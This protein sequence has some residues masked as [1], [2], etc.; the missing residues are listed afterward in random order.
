MQTLTPHLLGIVLL[1]AG[2]LKAMPDA[3]SQ[4]VYS[5]L[6][7]RWLAAGEVALEI[8]LGLWLIF[9]LCAKQARWSAIAIFLVLSATAA[10]K[11]F[12][13]Q[14]SCN[15]FGRFIEVSPWIMF[16][17][18]LG[19]VA[20]LWFWRPEGIDKQGEPIPRATG[21]V[22]F[23]LA[24]LVLALAGL[25]ALRMAYRLPSSELIVKGPS[26]VEIQHADRSQPVEVNFVLHNRTLHDI[27]IR[28]IHTGCPRV[29]AEI[30]SKTIGGGQ[31]ASLA[32]RIHG[33]QEIDTSFLHR[34][35]VD[36]DVGYIILWVAGTLPASQTI[37]YRPHEL[38]LVKDDENGEWRERTVTI[39]IPKSFAEP[40]GD[41]SI[42]LTNCRDSKISLTRDG[43][44]TDHVEY[45]LHFL[46]SP[47]LASDWDGGAIELRMER[48]NLNIPVVIRNSPAKAG[49]P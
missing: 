49:R 1:A 14:E 7:Y 12:L 30:P 27:S 34:I 29:T 4:E 40:L 17:F 37:F 33:F 9:G 43:Q 11:G 41:T 38:F 21:F 20:G 2:T 15:C 8:T 45:T 6:G 42:T 3:Y 10:S 18:D 36:T 23:A 44:C 46:P 25:S 47:D 5:L 31:D 16:A 35:Q 26:R 22:F 19:A 39:R 48:T 32:V 13:G 24:G 28:Q